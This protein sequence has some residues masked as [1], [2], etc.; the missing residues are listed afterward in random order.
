MKRCGLGWVIL[1]LFVVAHLAVGLSHV[2]AQATYPERPIKLISTFAPGGPVEAV[3]L[4]IAAAAKKYLPQP[5]EVVTV[6]G[7]AGITGAAEAIK[8]KPDGY[9]LAVSAMGPLTIQTHLLKAPFGPPDDY[10]PI[11]NLINNPVC[12]AVRS[13]SPFKT[14]KELID[15]AR[16][17]P[18]KL[19]VGSFVPG[20]VLHLCAEQLSLKAGIKFQQALV[21]AA[22]LALNGLLSGHLDAVS[23]H[24]GVFYK[25]FQ[26]GKVRILGVFEAKRNPV[27][28]DAPTFRELGY[29][30]TTSSYN[31]IIGPKNLPP[32][33]LATLEN[34]LRKA[35]TD[36]IFT[37]AMKS[38]G[39]DVSY[40]GSH[41]LRRHLAVDYIENEKLLASIGLIKT[42]TT[43]PAKP[44]EIIVPFGLGTNVERL[45]QTTIPFLQKEL[46]QDIWISF[47][48][49]D[50]GSKGLA[51]V[52]KT[53]RGGYVLGFT[54][55]RPLL[56]NPKLT[57][58]DYTL[59]DFK[60][61][62]QVGLFYTGLV[63]PADSKWKTAKEFIEEARKNPEAFAYAS[64]GEFSLPHLAMEYFNQTCGLKVKHKA[65]ESSPAAVKA[66]LEGKADLTMT[67][68]QA[69]FGKDGKTRILALATEKRLPEWPD[70]PTLKELGYEVVFDV[71]QGLVAHK[72]T[73][74]SVVAKLEGA[75]KTVSEK[76]EYRQAVSK[77][78]GAN[79]T[80][81]GSTDWGTKWSKESKIFE[82]V[83]GK[84]GARK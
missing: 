70:V 60:P 67:D 9:T 6:A 82:E 62:A 24:H 76:P 37:E 54:P 20:S 4:A 38:K 26:E 77:G 10:T 7:E 17:N 29:D 33:V 46:G 41:D 69:Q 51:Q 75:M 66:V 81:L 40:E 71:W 59:G 47:V 19:R 35:M 55:P 56:V 14:A 16:A 80:F 50:G 1:S 83:L 57:K 12:L 53:E 72:N 58:T 64:G 3:A 31:P 39:M 8:A 84:L 74:S 23:Q 42:G 48:P 30:I 25:A 11:I 13:D 36:P 65:F 63:V 5:M 49:G 68:I 45:L 21:A 34:A 52:A 32:N 2:Y 27:Y 73:P 78:T 79:V 22:P 18:G 61:V 15:Y 43:F 28:P 44:I